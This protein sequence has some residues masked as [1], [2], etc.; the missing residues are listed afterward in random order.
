MHEAPDPIPAGSPPDPRRIPALPSSAHG[1]SLPS[2]PHERDAVSC[3]KTSSPTER[4][5]CYLLLAYFTC[6]AIYA[7]RCYNDHLKQ[8]DADAAIFTTV[9]K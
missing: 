6:A 5:G 3:F 8:L 1:A 4:A 2:T 9:P 7:A